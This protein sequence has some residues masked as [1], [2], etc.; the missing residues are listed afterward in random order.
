MFDDVLTPTDSAFIA[1][2]NEFKKQFGDVVAKADY[3]KVSNPQY[4]QLLARR[5]RF[6][7][8]L[9][10]DI[11]DDP[12]G[13]MFFDRADARGLTKSNPFLDERTKTAVS[14]TTLTA[15]LRPTDFITFG[16]PKTFSHGGL[17]G[18]GVLEGQPHN[19]VHNNVG[20]IITTTG[21]DGKPVTTFGKGFMQANLSPVDPL[22]FLHHAN[23]DRIWDVWT[24]KQQALGLPILPDGYL[25]PPGGQP[26]PGGLLQLV[27]GTVP[28][29]HRCEG[30]AGQQDGGPRLRVDRRFR[31]RL[32]AGVRRRGGAEASRRRAADGAY[33]GPPLQRPDRESDRHGIGSRQRRRRSSVRA[34]SG[35]GRA[36]RSGSARQDYPCPS[37]AR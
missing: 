21:P 32:S 19:R 7:E 20:G 30:A 4:E 14:A 18:F 36:E 2:F 25:L 16:S 1:S 26:V 17:T 34:A 13:T 6:P 12:R 22:F 37:A 10:F 5:I 35:R 23:I 9:W 15:A 29:L 24:R 31:L 8:D 27:G 28:V 33:A 11:N 3:W